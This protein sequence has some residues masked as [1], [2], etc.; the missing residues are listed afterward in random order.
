MAEQSLPSP[1]KLKSLL[2]LSV[3]I[4]KNIE[5]QRKNVKTLLK[6][7]EKKILIVGPCSVSSEAGF[8]KYAHLLS[9]VYKTLERD[10]FI[11]LR[12]HIEKPRSCFGWKG[13]LYQPEPTQEENLLEGLIRSRKLLIETAKLGLPLAMEILSPLASAYFDDLISFG[14]L[15]A[16]T[17]CSQI[18]RECLS[19][20]PYPVGIK[21][22][23]S[24]EIDSALDS[25]LSCQNPHSYFGL[26]QEGNICQKSSCGNSDQC[27][28][29][30]GG[31][32]L[33]HCDKGFILKA[34]K[35]LKNNGLCP[36]PMVDCGHGN[37]KKCLKTQKENFLF[38]TALMEDPNIPLLGLVLES[39]LKE[40]A[41]DMAF[42]L[43]PEISLTDPCLSFEETKELL[44]EASTRLRGLAQL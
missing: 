38:L 8:L 4:K 17:C 1:K 6:N 12:A 40:G 3:D 29:L 25:I 9:E 11:I 27:L 44:L 33:N 26:S 32:N 23:L 15:G 16:R 41:Q 31:R 39:Y 2:P 18:H 7:P 35:A 5:M 19:G 10:F 14:T 37:S 22:D 36:Y 43:D 21:N 42:N 30:R 24:G 28:V 13:F 20:L 34:S